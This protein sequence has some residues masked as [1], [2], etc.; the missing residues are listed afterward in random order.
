MQNFKDLDIKKLEKSKIQRASI[1]VRVVDDVDVEKVCND[2]VRALY[3]TGHG[4]RI[5]V[6]VKRV[7]EW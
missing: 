7:E 5:S 6:E 1:V 2:L 3:R 4:P